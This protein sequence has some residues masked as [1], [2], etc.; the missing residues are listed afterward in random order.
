MDRNIVICF[1]KACGQKLR[2]PVKSS[3]GEIVCPKC[4]TKYT[5]IN[6]AV[7]YHDNNN[8]TELEALKTDNNLLKKK[9]E[10]LK[11]H[12]KY[13]KFGLV[14]VLLLFFGFL[15][16]RETPFND[17]KTLNEAAINYIDN[18]DYKNFNK[19]F[20]DET[21]KVISIALKTNLY[22]SNAENKEKFKSLINSIKFEKF[23]PLGVFEY[24]NFDNQINEIRVNY[25]RQDD[26]SYKLK[27]DTSELL[28]D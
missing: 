19:I 4:S 2:Y 9:N 3:K 13:Y 21:A 15:M 7:K 20:E 6:G 12:S 26:G 11:S 22:Y 14:I 5:V 27:I 24:K 28:G 16:S 8:N 23:E 18:E 25:I 17:Y 1:K 10:N